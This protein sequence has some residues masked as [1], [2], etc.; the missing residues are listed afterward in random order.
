MRALKSIKCAIDI[1]PPGQYPH[2][3]NKLKTKKLQE[4]RAAEIQL[5]NRQDAKLS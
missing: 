2:L 3:S 5:E 1:Q 4:D